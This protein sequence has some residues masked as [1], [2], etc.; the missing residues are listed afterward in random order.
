MDANFAAVTVFTLLFAVSTARISLDHSPTTDTRTTNVEKSSTLSES[1]IIALPTEN[2]NMV[3]ERTRHVTRKDNDIDLNHPRSDYARFH[4]INRHFSDQ[5]HR[6][7]SHRFGKSRPY[8]HF[9]NPFVVP[10]SEVSHIDVEKYQHEVPAKRIKAKHENKHHHHHHHQYHHHHIHR[11]DTNNNVIVRKHRFDH[12]NH[13][14]SNL[15]HRQEEIKAQRELG[16]MRSI[17][18]F[19]KH[20]FD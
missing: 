4:A 12:E 8:R 11:D 14:K 2:K 6:M 1:S 20:T 13:E 9:L 7:S 18:K 16:F 3:S 17:R 10:R 19:L 5:Q 15:V